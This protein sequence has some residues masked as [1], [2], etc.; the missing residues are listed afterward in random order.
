MPEETE[1]V[2]EYFRKLT[3]ELNG[4][5]RTFV[6]EIKIDEDKIVRMV[7]QKMASGLSARTTESRGI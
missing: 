1:D 5:N 4:L 3:R 7:A 2:L 6:T